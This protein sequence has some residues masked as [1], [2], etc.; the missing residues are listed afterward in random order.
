MS[1]TPKPRKRLH[2]RPFKEPTVLSTGAVARACGVTPDGVLHWIHAGKLPAFRTPGGHFRVRREDLTEFLRASG[3]HHPLPQHTGG[4]RVLV[5]D[6]EAPF[7]ELLRELLDHAGYE[8]MVAGGAGE[9]M[10]RIA[11]H[12][13]DLVITDIAMPGENGAE[14]TRTLRQEPALAQVPVIAVT[15]AFN[16]RSLTDIYQAGADVLLSKPVRLEHLLAEV[17]RLLSDPHRR[18][19]ANGG[20]V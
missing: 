12:R 17:H 10:E 6:D 11:D 2:S 7:R 19:G 16:E 15:G 13:P 18:P 5:V 20:E 8:V 4:A 3:C 1:K 14:L 9:A